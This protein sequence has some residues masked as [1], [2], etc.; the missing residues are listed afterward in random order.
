MNDDAIK[1]DSPKFFY[2]QGSCSQS[3]LTVITFK[4]ECGIR[5]TKTETVRHHGL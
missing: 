4:H 5:A 1:T 3:N 2:I